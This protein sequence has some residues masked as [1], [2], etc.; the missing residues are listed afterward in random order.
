M[1]DIPTLTIVVPCYNE[2][3]VVEETAKRLTEL[4]ERIGG[5]LGGF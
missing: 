1:K 3:L 5:G 2:E 4:I